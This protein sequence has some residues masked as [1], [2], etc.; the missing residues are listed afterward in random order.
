MHTI[1]PAAACRHTRIQLT[2]SKPA[3]FLDLTDRLSE[4]I[5]ESGVRYGILNVQTLHTTAAVVVNEH[6]PLLL[7][8]CLELLQRA[9]PAGITY[10]HDDLA[11]RSVNVTKEERRNGHAHCRALLLPTSASL[12]VARGAL[13]L[14]RWQRV[15]FVELDGPQTREVSVLVFG[16]TWR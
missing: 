11:L 16:E 13:V 3:E 2:T 9:A 10:R 7:D 14:G 15:F 6:E 12:N 5:R 1:A 8:D 4:L